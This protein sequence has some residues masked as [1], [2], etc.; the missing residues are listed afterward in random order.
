LQLRERGK[1]GKELL[2]A[3]IQIKSA[4]GETAQEHYSPTEFSLS[5]SVLLFYS[6]F[7]AARKKAATRKGTNSKCMYLFLSVCVFALQRI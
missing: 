6:P 7:Q 4:E 3:R 2:S 1:F 5:L